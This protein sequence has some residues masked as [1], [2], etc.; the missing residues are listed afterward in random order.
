VLSDAKAFA[1]ALKPLRRMNWF[2]YAKQPFAGSK[3]VLAYLSRYTHRVA[4]SN[5]RLIAHDGRSV[6]FRYKDYRADGP[7]RK[8][9]MTLDADEFIRRFL[10]HV[11]PKGAGGGSAGLASLPLLRRPYDRHRDHRAR[12]VA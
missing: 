1:S 10:I 2:V 3:A 7:D 6:T 5:S 9:V 4:I 12:D 8:K 11:L